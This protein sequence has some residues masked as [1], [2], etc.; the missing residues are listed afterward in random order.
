LGLCVEAMVGSFSSRRV[1]F[2]ETARLCEK[3]TRRIPG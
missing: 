2:F 1:F 3:P